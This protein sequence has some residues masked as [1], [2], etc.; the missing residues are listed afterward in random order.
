MPH[1]EID[2]YIDGIC[3]EFGSLSDAFD[4]PDEPH[5]EESH[6]RN[7]EPHEGNSSDLPQDSEITGTFRPGGCLGT[8]V[9]M[10]P[11]NA[12][13]AC[14]PQI[15]MVLPADPL[16][17]NRKVTSHQRQRRTIL[18][19]QKALCA[20]HRWAA[21]CRGNDVILLTEQ[22]PVAPT[23]T[24]SH[25]W[26]NTLATPELHIENWRLTLRG[27][28]RSLNRQG[29]SSPALEE[30]KEFVHDLE[31][32]WDN[33][34]WLPLHRRHGIELVKRAG[35]PAGLQKQALRL[36]SYRGPIDP[37]LTFHENLNAFRELHPDINFHIRLAAMPHQ[38]PVRFCFL[39]GEAWPRV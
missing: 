21:N 23:I 14:T 16:R 15:L 35:I 6:S 12:Q 29:A 36:F 27:L 9:N 19:F 31:I 2:H 26:G 4:F 28:F 38:K 18:Y 22:W 33:G 7:D 10:F 5:F 1:E 25:L 13:G 17:R 39:S 32:H 8:L 34:W 20:L 30:L 3:R 11:A 37:K 24:D